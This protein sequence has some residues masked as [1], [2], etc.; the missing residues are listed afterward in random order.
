MQVQAEADESYGG[1]LSGQLSSSVNG[2][3]YL[4]ASFAGMLL[5]AQPGSYDITFSLINYQASCHITCFATVTLPALQLSQLLLHASPTEYDIMSL[6]T[7]FL[8]STIKQPVVKAELNVAAI[9]TAYAAALSCQSLAGCT[10]LCC[11]QTKHHLHRPP[12]VTS[13]DMAQQDQTDMS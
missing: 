13:S 11:M 7:G 2:S 10:P 3:E 9:V 12:S 1:I 5:H 8:Q 6:Q 4:N